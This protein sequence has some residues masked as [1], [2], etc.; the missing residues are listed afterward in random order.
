MC[1]AE[2]AIFGLTWLLLLNLTQHP[3]AS[4]KRTGF[5]FFSCCCV[6]TVQTVPYSSEN[7]T[8]IIEE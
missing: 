7:V 8:C 1:F 6:W 5:F 4:A 2:N 3:Q